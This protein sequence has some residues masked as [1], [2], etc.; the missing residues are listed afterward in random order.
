[1]AAWLTVMEQAGEARFIT[2]QWRS[3]TTEEVR[4]TDDYKE[5]EPSVEAATNPHALE[6][7]GG[8]P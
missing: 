4:H 2:R 3:L 8:R 6:R 5:I 1:M 7:G